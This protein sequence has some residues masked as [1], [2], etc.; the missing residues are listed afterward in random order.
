[1]CCNI[2][3]EIIKAFNEKSIN[4]KVNILFYYSDLCVPRGP[5]CRCGIGTQSFLYTN[6]E[7]RTLLFL[8]SPNGSLLSS[9]GEV[10]TFV[11]LH[12]K[13]TSHQSWSP[14]GLMTESDT[15]TSFMA[16]SICLSSSY[17][18]LD[19]LSGCTITSSICGNSWHT[20]QGLNTAVAKVWVRLV[21][22]G[23][24]NDLLQF[25]T[26]LTLWS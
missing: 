12:L 9:R 6:L 18:S 16:S 26:Q 10:F 2:Q 21:S 5:H 20:G 1:M 4:K 15:P 3:T 8:P 14:Q 17:R 22:F 23:C 24:E 25:N 11:F 7:T 13:E 19:S